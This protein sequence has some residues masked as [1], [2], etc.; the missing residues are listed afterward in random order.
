MVKGINKIEKFIYWLL[1]SII[2]KK[3]HKCKGSMFKICNTCGVW[4]SDCKQ[5][6]LHKDK[7][8][9]CTKCGYKEE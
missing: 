8:W 9:L 3:C 7:S 1:H 5:P 4:I 6:T 2:M